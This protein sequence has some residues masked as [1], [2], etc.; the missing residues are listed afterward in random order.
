MKSAQNIK[1]RSLAEKEHSFWERA[2]DKTQGKGLPYLE[3]ESQKDGSEWKRSNTSR[4]NVWW[5][6]R[7]LERRKPQTDQVPRTEYEQARRHENHT[8]TYKKATKL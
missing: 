4:E 2:G 5:I 8:Q 6:S 3:L 7:T 1:A